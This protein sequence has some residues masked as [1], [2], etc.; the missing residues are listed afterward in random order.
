VNTSRRLTRSAARTARRATP[1]RRGPAPREA[2][3]DARERL[4]LEAPLGK[5]RHLLPDRG[6][7]D[8]ELARKVLAGVR[9]AV[10]QRAQ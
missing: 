1:P 6:A 8:A 7:R 5:V 3:A 10:S 9:L 4:D 2:V